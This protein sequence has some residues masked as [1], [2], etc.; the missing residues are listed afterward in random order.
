MEETTI[1]VDGA[2]SRGN[3]GDY[4]IEEEPYRAGLDGRRPSTICVIPPLTQC[5]AGIVL[6]ESIQTT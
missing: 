6:G 5:A 4:K 2:S 3:G 1:S